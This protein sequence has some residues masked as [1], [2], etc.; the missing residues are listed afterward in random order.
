MKTAADSPVETNEENENSSFVVE[1]NDTTE[2]GSFVTEAYQRG[3]HS[4]V[5]AMEMELRNNQWALAS[6]LQEYDVL[7][8]FYPSE[9]PS[10]DVPVN[11][12]ALLFSRDEDVREEAY[13]KAKKL[14]HD[15]LAD[16][17]WEEFKKTDPRSDDFDTYE[18]YQAYLR[19]LA[20]PTKIRPLA[21]IAETGETISTEPAGP[22]EGPSD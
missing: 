5:Q 10:A 4:V 15:S 12:A 8:E 9:G 16:A 21:R 3:D 7:D 1:P 6:Y 18:E 20:A 17:A 19:N 11:A 2:A 14:F 13:R 22:W